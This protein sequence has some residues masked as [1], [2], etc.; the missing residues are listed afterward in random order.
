MAPIK[1]NIGERY[2]KYRCYEDRR[3]A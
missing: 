1:S 2:V 3:A